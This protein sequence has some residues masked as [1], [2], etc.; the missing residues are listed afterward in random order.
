MSNNG[1]YTTQLQAGL[2]LIQ[3]TDVLFEHWDLY[4]TASDLYERVLEEGV[5]PNVSARRL[6]NIVAECFSPRYLKGDP[7]PAV[8]IKQLKESFSA[9]ELHQLYF[10]YTCRANLILADF[11]R[12]V[13]WDRYQSGSGY[14]SSHYATEFINGAMDDGKTSKRW[15]DATVKRVSAY[16]MGACGDYGLLSPSS[17]NERQILSYRIEPKV[18]VFMAHDIHFQ[19]VKDNALLQH[20]DWRLFGLETADIREEFKRMSVQGHCIFQSAANITNIS[21]IYASMEDVIDVHT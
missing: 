14:I 2:G 18:A 9:A 1:L 5:F 7:A 16:L 13:Y 17:R 12:E 3:E 21:W 11:V 6:R 20:E 19:G 4:M 15:S 8:Y 10:L